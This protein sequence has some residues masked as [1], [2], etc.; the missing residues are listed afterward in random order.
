MK[1]SL[2]WIAVLLIVIWVIARLTLAVTS[3][4]LHILWIVAVIMIVIWLIG[5]IRKTP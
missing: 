5:L 3:L 2:L 4:A 1:H